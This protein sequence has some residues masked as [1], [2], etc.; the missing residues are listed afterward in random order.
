LDRKILLD[1]LKYLL[2]RIKE[3][4]FEPGAYVPVGGYEAIDYA[5]DIMTTFLDFIR[6]STDIRLKHELSKDIEQAIDKAIEFLV[7]SVYEDS[8][9]CRWS[10]STTVVSGKTVYGH[11]Y[12]TCSAGNA[13]YYALEHYKKLEEGRIERLRQLI[14]GSHT[15]LLK[16]KRGERYYS[17]ET[18]RTTESTSALYNADMLFSTWELIKDPKI[19]DFAE[20]CLKYYYNF[21]ETSRNEF[22]LE[23][24]Y[25]ALVPDA[26]S[27]VWVD[28]RTTIA[29]CLKVFCLGKKVLEK[30]DIIDQAFL[31]FLNELANDV[32][33]EMDSGNNVWEKGQY[34]IYSNLRAIEGLLLFEKYG[35]H[36]KIQNFSLFDYRRVVQAALNTEVV[37]KAFMDEFRKLS[38]PGTEESSK[39]EA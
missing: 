22:N 27:P 1:D 35:A 21:L 25:P 10:G 36:E 29:N 24:F 38:G 26:K 17:D 9:G 28:D 30:S 34:L 4:G 33:D 23:V 8:N 31:S 19:K 6:Y 39:E 16:R 37:M 12:F 3:D 32:I 7:G 20:E 11:V 5:A 18:F 2:D 13:L 14:Q 15:W